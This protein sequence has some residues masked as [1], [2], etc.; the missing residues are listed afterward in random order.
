[1]RLLGETAPWLDPSSLVRLHARGEHAVVARLLATAKL[2]ERC[3]AFGHW[4]RHAGA[5]LGGDPRRTAATLHAR[6]KALARRSKAALEV[7]PI[8]VASVDG[9]C[10]AALL[11]SGW[12][13]PHRTTVVRAWKRR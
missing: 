1:M 2:H 3:G 4:V 10:L 11:A 5:L 7:S 13:C 9:A 8:D 12:E 6:M